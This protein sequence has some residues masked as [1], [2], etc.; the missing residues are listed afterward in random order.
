MHFEMARAL[1]EAGDAARARDHAA[2]AKALGDA[3][4]DR[5]LQQLAKER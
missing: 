1:Q 3:R 5:L 4:A 2:K